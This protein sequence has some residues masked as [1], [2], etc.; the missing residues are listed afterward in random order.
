VENVIWGK[1]QG[2]PLHAFD[3]WYY[4]ETTNSKGQTSRSYSRF[5]CVV[6]PVDAS[7]PPL[8]IDHENLFTRLADHLAMHDIEFESDEFNKAYNVKGGDERFATAFID[9]RMMA[10]LLAHGGGFAFEVSGS[11]LLVACRRLD[12]MAMTPVLGTARDFLA[13][14]PGVV[15]SMYPKSG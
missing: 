13:Q 5:E 8:T 14:V 9:A 10:W 11:H 7:C 1:W 4:E 6:V 15:F 2:T 12:P 3:Y